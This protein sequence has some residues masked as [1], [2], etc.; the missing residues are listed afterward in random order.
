MRLLLLSLAL[1]LGASQDTTFQRQF[2]NKDCGELSVEAICTVQD[3][4][5]TCWDP[6]GNI[7]KK[8]SEEVAET[9]DRQHHTIPF[10]FD[11]MNRYLVVRS[12]RF[13][14]VPGQVNLGYY[15]ND[16]QQISQ[17]DFD[18]NSDGMVERALYWG[19][20]DPDAKTLEMPFEYLLPFQGTF[21]LPCK[22]GATQTIKGR[23]LTV[24]SI[25]VYKNPYPMIDNR[26]LDMGWQILIDVD[27]GP[28][29]G[30]YQP[31]ACA[32]DGYEIRAIDTNH[33]PAPYDKQVEEEAQRSQLFNA[34]LAVPERKFQKAGTAAGRDP[35]GRISVITNIRPEGITTIKLSVRDRF[36]A[37]ISGLAVNPK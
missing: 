7:L 4:K 29:M 27:G 19:A 32:A 22:V 3:A 31:T 12:V 10:R 20:F 2:K 23:K 21:E 17:I 5:A 24:S 26:V 6:D 14:G 28:T 9:L 37:T 34:G 15:S 1:L 11:R 30:D 36:R 8:R 33:L 35:K 18:N 25:E 16:F 13:N